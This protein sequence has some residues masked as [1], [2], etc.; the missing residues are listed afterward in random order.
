MDIGKTQ[1]TAN[2]PAGRIPI[3]ILG[4]T[5]AV[6]Q[7][8]IQLLESHPWFR[9][10]AVAASERSVG[11]RYAEACAWKLTTPIPDEIADLVVR[12]LDPS[13]LG[14]SDI[15]LA[16]SALPADVATQTEPEFVAAGFAVSS[17]AAAFRYEPDV[18]IVL[19]DVNPDHLALLGVQRRT[20]S[21][22]GVLVTNPNCTTSGIALV[23][24]PL[25][26]AFG[27]Q[28]VI[29]S[30]M[31]AISGAGYPGIPSLDILGNVVPWISGEEEKIERESALLLGTIDDGRQLPATFA[32]GAH[33]NRVPVIDGHTICMS[34]GFERSHVSP[35]AVSQVL[36]AFGGAA[37][38]CDLPS[39]PRPPVRVLS[40]PDR[41]QPRLDRGAQGGMQVSVGRIRECPVLDVRLVA[42]VHNT[43][44]GAAGGSILNAELLA[45]EGWLK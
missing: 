12:P 11:R 39:A 21:W 35:T 24:K 23:L 7:R 18:P 45:R 6:G 38:A 44:R 14:R 29:V 19:P 43:V 41:P 4:A 36:S 15:R 25:Q 16:F 30:T 22:R 13:K 9:V 3:A 33:A 26:E 10:A 17:N 42:V 2:G 31:Q 37:T 28:R 40:A 20:R 8:F 1:P 27:L 34:I 32:I 5:G